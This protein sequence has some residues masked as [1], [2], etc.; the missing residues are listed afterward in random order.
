MEHSREESDYNK[1]ERWCRDQISSGR[2][3]LFDPVLFQTELKATSKD[4]NFPLESLQSFFRNKYVKHIKSN[5][6]KVRDNMQTKYIKEYMLGKSIKDLAEE[7]NFSPALLARRVVEE[8]TD[9]GKKGLSSAMKNP[10]E[11]L[12]SINTIKEKYRE[13]EERGRKSSSLTTKTTRLAREVNEA[14]ASDPL[15]GP[16]TDRERH[17][18]GIEYEIVLERGLKNLGKFSLLRAYG[19]YMS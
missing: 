3:I 11:E 13:S 7:T 18:I 8:M 10:L 5:S 14:I 6:H 19:S 2:G 15:C 9:L 4:F 1:V 17:F 16:A 12:G